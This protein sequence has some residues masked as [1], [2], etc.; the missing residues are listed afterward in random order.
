MGNT[1]N[2]YGQAGAFGENPNATNTQQIWQS[3]GRQI[4]LPT[5]A[6]ELAKFRANLA[7]E[8]SAQE[9]SPDLESI[10]AAENAAKDGNGPGALEHLKSAGA[11]VWDTGTKI[12]IG[13]AI[14]AAKTALG[15]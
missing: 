12:G 5:L 10:A 15:L 3:S 4:D 8:P 2:N 9:H 13:V 6:A 11:W 14:V 1:Y 7:K